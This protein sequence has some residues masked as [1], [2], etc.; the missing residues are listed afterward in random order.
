[1]RHAAKIVA[2]EGRECEFTIQ[3][4][5]DSSVELVNVPDNLFLLNKPA[6]ESGS[7]SFVFTGKTRGRGVVEFLCEGERV[8]VPSVVFSEREFF[9]CM[10]ISS[11]YHYGWDPLSYLFGDTP[12]QL[13]LEGH[14]YPKTRQLEKMYH[15]RGIPITWL[16]DKHV[17][18]EAATDITDWHLTYGDDYGLMPTSNFMHNEINFN[19]KKTF[20]ETLEMVINERDSLQKFFDWESGVIGIDQWVGSVGTHFVEA[21]Y[22]LGYNAIWGIGFDHTTCD[23][24]MF[25]RGCPWDV[26]KPSRDNFR[27]PSSKKGSLWVFQWTTRDVINTFH[28]PEGGPGGS[29]IFSTD[30][31]DVRSTKIMEN[32]PDYWQR[33]L[34][35]YKKNMDKNDFFVFLVHQEDHDCHFPE[36]AAYIRNFLD[37]MPEGVTYATIEEIAEWLNIKFGYSDHPRQKLVIDD[38]LACQDDV[39]F[40]CGIVKPDDWPQTGDSYP[41]HIAY[42]DAKRMF[43]TP[44]DESGPMRWYDYEAQ[45]T[46]PED[47]EYPQAPCPRITVESYRIC[48]DEIAITVDSDGN[49]QKLP[50]A[51]W[52]ADEE[53]L[54]RC[55]ETN[56]VRIENHAVVFCDVKK[57]LHE[58][59]I[60]LD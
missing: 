41:E 3:C 24:S 37:T 27:V 45:L 9:V 25:H 6:A 39:F 13:D 28:S 2:I 47:G 33:M 8:L 30:A 58:Y 17:A 10:T 36:D 31:D 53:L 55:D 40:Y 11:N 23:S 26:Y 51:I 19:T 18:S 16:I 22:S 7:V 29:V 46:S 54:S 35:E 4:T 32:Q 48:G 49:A 50:I 52:D 1:M 56:A 60:A 20:A 12:E 5:S 14:A 59:K 43:V 21:A 44:K 57:G 42:Y 38:P 34:G 15:T